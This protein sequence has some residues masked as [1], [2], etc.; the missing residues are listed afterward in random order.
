MPLI[1]DKLYSIRGKMKKRIEDFLTDRTQEVLVEGESLCSGAIISGVPQGSVLGPT[2]FL[3]SINN[4]GDGIQA[5]VRLFADDTELYSH[6]RTKKDADHLH[7]D[8]KKL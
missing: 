8:L 1:E 7:S 2:L 5:H 4:L 3:L 6:I